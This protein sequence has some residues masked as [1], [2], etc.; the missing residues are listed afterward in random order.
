MEVCVPD[1]PLTDDAEVLGQIISLLKKLSPDE[2]RR[3]FQTTG[4]FFQFEAS[5]STVPS[6]SADLRAHYSATDAGHAL[7]TQPTFSGDRP[8]SPKQ[9]LNERS[10]ERRV[11]KECR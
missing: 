4:T 8:P 2:R 11:G 10:E 7:S 9:F 6:T 3:I 1:E 5:P